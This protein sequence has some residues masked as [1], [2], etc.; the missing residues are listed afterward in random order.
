[1]VSQTNEA[2][3]ETIIEQYLVNQN[4][5]YQGHPSNFNKQFA[6][7]TERLWDFLK[8]T[9][10][11]ELTKLQRQSDWE[12]KLLE[13]LD[14]II[15]KYGILH[16][17]RKGLEVDDANFTFFYVLPLASSSQSIKDNFAKNQ[18]SITRQVCYSLSNPLEEIDMVLFVNGLPLISMELKNPWT[19]QTAKLHGQKQYKYE[20]S[21]SEP[22]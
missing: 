6:I 17:L 2:A 20:R 8:E 12:R 10:A 18:F 22:L 7:D 21:I 9:Q 15:K 11:S 3:L 14:R 5:F 19:G 13:R 16:V 4:G 1:M